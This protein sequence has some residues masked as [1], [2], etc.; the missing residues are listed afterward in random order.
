MSDDPETTPGRLARLREQSRHVLRIARWEMSAGAG[1]LDRRTLLTALVLVVAIAAV[2]GAVAVAGTPQD[3]NVYRVGVSPDSP[4]HDP[5]ASDPSLRVVDPDGG[6]Y[7]DREIEV[8]IS[9]GVL[10]AYNTSKGR[11]AAAAVKSAVRRYNE[12]LMEAE[13][14]DGNETAAFPV[15]VELRYVDRGGISV[16]DGTDDGGGGGT[17]DG[18]TGGTGDGGTGG[19][20]GTDDGR[21]GPDSTATPRPAPSPTGTAETPGGG[22]DVEEGG[23]LGGLPSIGGEALFGSSKG[24]P[25]DIRPPFPFV[26]LVLAFAFVVPMNFVIQAYASSILGERTNRRGELTLIAPVSPATIVAGKTVPYFAAMLVIAAITTLVLGG[27]LVS[28]GAVTPIALL[29]LSAA[30][31]GGMLARSHKE[32][33]FVLVTVSVGITSYVFLPA[34]FTNVTPI[35]AISPLTMVVR[36]LEGVTVTAPVFL[37]ST[38]P[39]LV[40]SAVLFGLG[41][42]LYREE[43]L[44]AQ[45]PIPGKVVD[46]LAGPIRGTKSVAGLTILLL[47]FV[48]LAE[49]LAVAVLF[50]LPRSVS[51][52]VLLAF[53]A[54]IE[55][56]GKSVHVLSGFERARFDRR[57]RTAAIVGT[58]SG[59]GFFLGEKVVALVQVVGLERLDVG[60]VLQTTAGTG[61]GASVSPVVL[62]GLF[63]APLAL[64]VVTAV[65]SAVGASRGRR[66]YVLGLAG[67][68][69]V[70]TLYN[71]TVVSALV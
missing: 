62:I 56:I 46:A 21:T 38:V 25:S 16:G 23:G 19:T 41:G 37:F 51:L 68:V 54:T 3:A 15:S 11:S 44:F 40:A 63:L 31:L 9:R 52:P 61:V 20:G 2:G 39:M 42:G 28:I 30:F 59:A 36:E 1:G 27:G 32:L 66:T 57:L 53:I 50:V 8:L 13:A 55:E 22:G 47:P 4:Y 69:I 49:L 18:G 48:V 34:V 17:D 58:A 12:R 71:L 70:H 5:V 7:D 35:A 60:Q 24:R 43:D 65:V 14:D 6:A 10:R 26:S 67:A 33:T 64:H 29:F 45:K